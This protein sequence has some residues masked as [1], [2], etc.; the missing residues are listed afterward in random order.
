MADQKALFEF[1]L[2]MGDNSLIL[3]HRVSEWCGVAPVLEEDIALANTALDLIG[4][5]QFWLGLAGEVEGKGRTADDLAFLRDAWDFRNVLLCELPNGDF[6]RTLM[7]QFLFDAWSSVMLGRLMTSSDERI[8][9]IAAKA[10]KEVAYHVERSGD[11]VV[12]LGDGTEES[13]ARMQTALDYLWPYVGEMFD[14]DEVDAAMVKAGITPDP[15]SLRDEYDALVGKVLGQ[16]T[17]TI[18]TDTFHHTG[19]RTGYMHTEHLGHLLCT[20]QW[21]QRAYPGATW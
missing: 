5:T 6:G 21:L 1:L 15:A 17:L 18:P 12:G 10:S 4:Q 20:M 16:A 13:H 8:A 11:T 9:A 14:G 2:R 19:G 7:R 3:G